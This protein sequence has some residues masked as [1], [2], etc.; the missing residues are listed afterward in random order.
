VRLTFSILAPIIVRFTINSIPCIQSA[1]AA[2][3]APTKKSSRLSDR[4]AQKAT[5]QNHYQSSSEGSG[6]GNATNY[7]LPSDFPD[8]DATALYHHLSNGSDSTPTR[9]N[10]AATAPKVVQATPSLAAALANPGHVKASAAKL[11]ASSSSASGVDEERPRALLQDRPLS[12][13]RTAL[14]WV[15]RATTSSPPPETAVSASD[16]SN[17]QNGPS[18]LLAARRASQVQS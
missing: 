1:S 5:T 3:S 15:P 7:D 14:Q 17:S 16:S 11:L 13:G 10:T 8:R 4:L 12:S 2:S 6:N 9:P 18:S